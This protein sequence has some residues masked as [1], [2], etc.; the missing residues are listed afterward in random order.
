MITRA[1]VE[2]LGAFHAVQPKVLS[3]YLSVPASV[4]E[5]GRLARRVTEFIAAAEAD[6]G[7]SGCLGKQDRCLALELTATA[8]HDWPG[9]S[10]AI[11]AC[12]DIGLEEVLPLPGPRP[13][14]TVLGVRPHIRPLLDALQEHP[15]YWAAVLDG[16]R[17]WVF[18]AQGDEITATPEHELGRGER[19]PLVIGGRDDEVRLMLA[20]LTPIDR[21]IVVGCFAAE[22]GRPTPARL[23]ELA[24]P[25]IARWA[26]RRAS[27]L[28]D[29]ILDTPPGGLT[30]VG[31]PACLAAV[32]ADSADALIVPE[33]GL[34]PGYE[35]GRCGT[36]SLTPESC[37][38]W[39]TALLRV[40]DVIE[41]MVARILE[42]G[43]DVF[44][45]HDASAPVAAR[46]RL[47][48]P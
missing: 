45:T 32:S 31:V 20:S 23:L 12:D 36:L 25:V 11:F 48:A 1:E 24:E 41:E 34:V 2:K 14:R 6:A 16:R 22:A 7:P 44:V 39:G 18:R 46:L 21:A 30:A 4:T 8:A 15:A 28:A 13:D 26:A 10:V 42:D 33:S 17:T 29:E 5:Q 9:R 40:P 27:R 38:D 37:P 19:E 3:L 35:C 47:W 43:G